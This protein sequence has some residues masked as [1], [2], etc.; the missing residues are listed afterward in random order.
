VLFRQRYALNENSIE[1]FIDL[2]LD[3]IHR[4]INGSVKTRVEY[5]VGV[6]NIAVEPEELL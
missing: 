2:T 5:V 4:K 6:E 1:L 3:L